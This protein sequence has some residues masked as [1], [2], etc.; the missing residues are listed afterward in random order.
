MSPTAGFKRG[1]LDG[2]GL[3]ARRYFAQ[4]EETI[5][6]ELRVP[7]SRVWKFVKS[8]G[9]FGALGKWN[10]A[11]GAAGGSA[12]R[13]TQWL[14][15]G[16]GWRGSFGWSCRSSCSCS[17]ARRCAGIGFLFDAHQALIRDFPAE[18][19]VLAA[20]FELL[21]EEDRT[22]GIGDE[23]AG[24]RQKDI[25]GAIL[26]LNPAPEKGGVASHTVLSF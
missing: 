16:F 26:H 21:F 8:S 19:L 13:R 9:S 20:L 17:C 23:S 1:L 3:K 5:V 14:I 11:R 4:N 24:G 6:A 7:E 12:G 22:A 15:A 18:V 10:E 2:N 25:A